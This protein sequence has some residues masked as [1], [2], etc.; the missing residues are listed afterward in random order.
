[1]QWGTTDPAKLQTITVTCSEY[2]KKLVLETRKYWV[3]VRGIVL[4]HG[5]RNPL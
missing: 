2:I 1:M 4:S 3:D 5:E